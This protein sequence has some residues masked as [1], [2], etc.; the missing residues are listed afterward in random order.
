MKVDVLIL[1]GARLSGELSQ[2]SPVEHEAFIQIHDK[3]MVEYVVKAV[4]EAENTDKIAIVGP[5]KKIKENINFAFDLIVN[6]TDSLI[7]NVQRGINSLQPSKNVL[8][9]SSDIPLITSEVID[10]FIEL[11]TEKT[12]DIYYPIVSKEH[13]VA[14]YPG[15][16]RTYVKLTEGSF[17]GGNMVIINPGILSDILDWLKKAVLWRKKPLKLSKLLGVKILFK[18]LIGNL[19]LAEIEERVKKLTGYKGCGLITEHPEIGFDVDKPSDL[20]LM[21]EEFI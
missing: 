17:T 18:L 10:E 19:T 4:T 15:M 9:I 14:K 8:L 12:A 21:R 11:C 16:E 5:E 13:S 3:P 7:E 2:Y 6:S 20:E 1:A